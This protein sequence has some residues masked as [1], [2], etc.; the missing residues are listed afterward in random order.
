[1]EREFTEQEWEEAKRKAV[2][3]ARVLE[4]R[5]VGMKRPGWQCNCG[6]CHH[7]E[8]EV[9]K[10]VPAGGGDRKYR[11]QIGLEY[12]W[13]VNMRENGSVRDYDYSIAGLT[14]FIPEEEI[15]RLFAEYFDVEYR[16]GTATKPS[17]I[18]LD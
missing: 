8:A 1:M 18:V 6:A 9:V 7:G 13:S 15:Y 11:Y 2:E 12:L 14:Y 5:I 3:L 10:V 17:R 4:A 16:A